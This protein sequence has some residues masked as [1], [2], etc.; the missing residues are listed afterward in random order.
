MGPIRPSNVAEF[1]IGQSFNIF[2]E[3]GGPGGLLVRSR[4]T[5]GKEVRYFKPLN[6]KSEATLT[7]IRTPHILSENF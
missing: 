1:H 4:A 5:K 6:G 2:F 3:E 7:K